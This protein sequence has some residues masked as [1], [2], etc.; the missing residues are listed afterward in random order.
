MS[1]NNKQKPKSEVV[2]TTE[3]TIVTVNEPKFVTFRNASRMK[4]DFSF[5]GKQHS[6]LANGEFS[7][8]EDFADAFYNGFKNAG[9]WIKIN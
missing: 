9:P 7:V 4:V 3:E 1:K 2:D 6:V 8:E 5:R